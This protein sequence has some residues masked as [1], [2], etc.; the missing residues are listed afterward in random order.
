METDCNLK[1]NR[2]AFFQE[3]PAVK[4]KPLLTDYILFSFQEFSLFLLGVLRN[5]F[6]D[7]KMLLVLI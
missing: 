1:K 7:K 4:Q 6:V 3:F 2:T 5:Y